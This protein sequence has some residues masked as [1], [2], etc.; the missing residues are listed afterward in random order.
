MQINSN[1]NR[2][3][4]NKIRQDMRFKRRQLSFI[5]QQQAAILLR[6]NLIKNKH[7]QQAQNIGVY[8]ALNGEISLKPFIAWSFLQHKNI[9][10]PRI[11]TYPKKLLQFV[12]Y[13][14]GDLLLPA[15]YQILQPKTKFKAQAICTLDVILLPLVAFDDSGKRLGM[16]GGFYDRLLAQIHPKAKPY[17][18]GIAYSFQQVLNLPTD[19]WD[20]PLNA[21]ITDANSFAF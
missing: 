16:G 20:I 18:I 17:L 13:K 9:Y 5:K 15:K 11:Q 7:V 2:L 12:R 10:V 8:F 3:S 21:V 19:T 14:Q 6:Q 1:L 4:K